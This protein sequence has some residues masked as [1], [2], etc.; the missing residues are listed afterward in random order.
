MTSPVD[1]ISGPSTASTPGNLMKGNTASLMAMCFTSRSRV[2]PKSRSVAPSMTL[3]ASLASGT[4]M[5]L[6]TKGTVRD[7]RGFTSR[8]K[9]CSFLIANWMLRS[10]MTPSSAARARVWAWI[11]SIWSSP[12]E[13]GGS[14]HEDGIADGGGDA[15]GL[16]EGARHVAGGLQQVE[17]RQELGEAPA[18]LGAVDRVGRRAEDGHARPLQRD[19]QLQR[20]LPAELD[21]HAAGPLP[22]HDVHHV[23]EGE[24]LEV[25]TVGGVVVGGDR[26]RIAVDHDGLHAR[27]AKGEGSVDARIDELDP[28]ADTVRPGAQDDHLVAG[29][30]R[31]LVLLLVGGVEV[32]RVGGELGG[33]GVHHLEGGADAGGEPRRSRLELRR[34]RELGDASIGEAHLLGA[35]QHARV[36]EAGGLDRLLERHDLPDILQEPGRSEEHTSE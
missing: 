14:A 31:R 17:P 3:V 24:R 33:A 20:G 10:P 6:E 28:L 32:G 23:L 19:D 12:R 16:V 34:A 8:T 29:G 1:F 30:W 4:P 36:A 25:E 7:A 22:L 9:T 27:L 13:Y 5:A 2:R 11:R 18:I 21:D 15:R 35:S 26:L